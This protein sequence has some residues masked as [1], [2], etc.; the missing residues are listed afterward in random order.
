MKE[1]IMGVYKIENIVTNKV[2][3]G[4]TRNYLRRKHEHLKSLRNGKCHMVK[5]QNSW[6]KYGESNFCISLIEVVHV[7][8]TLIERED[9]WILYYDSTNREKGYNTYLASELINKLG[10]WKNIEESNRKYLLSKGPTNIKRISR[11]EWIQKRMDNPNFRME[12]YFYEKKGYCKRHVYRINIHSLEIEEEFESIVDAVNKY[13]LNKSSLTLS[14]KRN[15]SKPTTIS[16]NKGM[17]FVRKDDYMMPLLSPKPEKVIKKKLKKERKI[18]TNSKT[19]SLIHRE[20]NEIVILSSR[21]EGAKF[22][23][24]TQAKVFSLINGYMRAERFY[25][26]SWIYE[27]KEVVL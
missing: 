19:I 20:T 4:S 27:D 14:L 1:I 9:F 15:G 8:N 2:Y 25:I 10:G 11:E 21:S 17:A 3:I 6:N 5:L 23:K 16:I 26:S 7:E 13:N 22:L 18:P 12:K 24:C